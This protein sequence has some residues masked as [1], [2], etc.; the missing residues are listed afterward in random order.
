MKIT[1]IREEIVTAVSSVYRVVPAKASVETLEGIYLQATSDNKLTIKGYDLEIGIEAIIDAEVKEEGSVIVPAKLFYDI[2]KKAPSESITI[3]VSDKFVTSITSGKSRHRLTGMSTKDY[4]SLP[5]EEETDSLVIK[6][7]VLEELIKHTM[8]A[9]SNNT[10][11]PI[12]TGSLFKIKD[13][14]LTVVAIDGYQMSIRKYSDDSITNENEF[15]ISGKTQKE[16]LALIT[17]PEADVKIIVCKR[18][19]IILLDNYKIFTRMIEGN[20]IDY[21]STIPKTKK[22]SVEVDADELQKAI[23]RLMIVAV[24][25]INSPVKCEF[26]NRELHMTIKTPMGEAEEVVYLDKF[27]GNDVTIGFNGN[28]LYNGIKNADCENVTLIL[29][30]AISPMVVTDDKNGF[31]NLVV[32]MHLG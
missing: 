5:K 18:H 27:V 23:E 17:N 16:L 11:R 29:N 12:Y 25:K 21:N 15:V 8:Y 19:C 13:N 9:I 31:I 30:S 20:F 14:A 24:N 3:S 4:P 22:T 28:Y 7:G 1:V 2:V 10:S 6:A 32:P 26:V